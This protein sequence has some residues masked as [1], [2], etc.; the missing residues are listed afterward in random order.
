MPFFWFSKLIVTA[1]AFRSCSHGNEWCS[2]LLFRHSWMSRRRSGTVRVAREDLVYSQ[3]RRRKK[4]ATTTKSAIMLNLAWVEA[5]YIRA[6]RLTVE[7][8]TA[9]SGCGAGSWSFHRLVCLLNRSSSLCWDGCRLR[10]SSDP[11]V[12]MSLAHS[13]RVA[14]IVVAEA[15]LPSYSSPFLRLQ[16]KAMNTSLRST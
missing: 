12:T 2:I 1:S 13:R 6:R 7:F 9:C 4:Y 15:P 3:T 5:P 10:G 14:S 8:G 16:A 11:R